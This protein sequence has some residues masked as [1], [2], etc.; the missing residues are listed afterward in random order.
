MKLKIYEVKWRIPGGG[1]YVPMDPVAGG[2][3]YQDLH[4]TDI[5]TAK[6]A[7]QAREV[8]RK[9]RGDQAKIRRPEIVG[10]V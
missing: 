4:G 7:K 5:I 6:S 8:V 10:L 1:Q 3:Y 2:D 9:V